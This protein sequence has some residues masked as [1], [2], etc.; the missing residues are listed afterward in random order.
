MTTDKLMQSSELL[1]NMGMHGSGREQL[2]SGVSGEPLDGRCFIGVV[3]YQRL[4]FWS[5]LLQKVP[6]NRHMVADKIHARSLDQALYC[7]RCKERL[8]LVQLINWSVLSESAWH[9]ASDFD[10]HRQ[11]TEGRARQG[12]LRIGE[13]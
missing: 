7:K 12:G 1:H 6:K 8:K 9:F 4:Q 11:P 3:F 5:L 10:I 2:Y 13:I